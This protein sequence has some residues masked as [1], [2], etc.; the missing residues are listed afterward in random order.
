[1]SL[2]TTYMAKKKAKPGPK[3]SPE[4]VRDAL[5][6]VRCRSDFRAWVDD[7]AKSKHLP[8]AVLIEHCLREYAERH[9]FKTPMPDR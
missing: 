4:G 8:M 1:M 3:P 9:Q 5:V 6:S 2:A 7:L